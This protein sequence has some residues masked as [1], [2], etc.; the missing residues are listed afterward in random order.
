MKINMKNFIL[1][2]HFVLTTGCMIVTVVTY[3]YIQ[4]WKNTLENF[5]SQSSALTPDERLFAQMNIFMMNEQQQVLVIGVIINAV[6]LALLI[7]C[8]VVVLPR[9]KRSTDIEDTP[10]SEVGS[11]LK[12]F[13]KFFRC[14]AK[15]NKDIEDTPTSAGGSFLKQFRRFF[16]CEAKENKDNE[17]TE[18]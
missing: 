9:P 6:V 13:R 16:R 3:K 12:Q 10:T 14:E 11:F 18:V 5:M 2:I 1:A 17:V 4:N 15:E 8:F 7:C